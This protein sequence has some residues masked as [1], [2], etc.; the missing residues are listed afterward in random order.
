VTRK[1]ALRKTLPKDF[2]QM[3]EQAA[4]SGDYGAVHAILEAA[5]LEA[6][7]GY[8]KVTVLAM[9][10]CTPELA[11]WVVARGANV[12]ATDA[13]GC[14]ALHASARARFHRDLPPAVLIELGANIH[15]RD[16]YGATPLHF[17]A[18]GKNLA[19]VELLLARGAAVDVLDDNG[20]TP[21]E[22]ALQRLSNI[23]LVDMVPVAEALLAAGARVERAPE[24]V[25]RAAETFEFHR[26]GFAKDSVK[27]TATAA[28]T[29]CELFGVTPPAP[30]KLHDGVSPIVATSKTWHDQHAE[31]WDLLVPSGGACQTVQG[32]VVRIAGRVS[33]ELHRNGGVNW[34][35]DYDAM[36][37]AFCLHLG[38]HAALSPSELE[39]CAALTRQR[40]RISTDEGEGTA[41]LAQ[42]AVK[43]VSLNPTPV[44]LSPPAYKR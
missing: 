22:Y 42:L 4:A 30:R 34:N 6:R 38:S 31:L 21:L 41:R 26:A 3:L 33:D 19:S 39:E 15:Q 36:L 29:L 1:P 9:R 13:Y 10:Q 23:D 27:E 5:E 17:A 24:F 20:L 37:R 43:W 28:R 14:T 40:S 16:K 44:P 2:E 8:A 11:R 25:K 7:G 32:E 35:A 12:D 18:D